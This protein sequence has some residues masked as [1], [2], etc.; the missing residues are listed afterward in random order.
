[1]QVP[2]RFP[3]LVSMIAAGL[4]AADLPYA[5]K[6]KLN[7]AKS[8]FGQLTV[9]YEQ[10]PGGE[11][12]VNVDGLSYSFKTDGQSYTT[13]WGTTSAW[14][15]IDANTWETTN[16]ANGKLIGTDTLKLSPDGKTL[17]I[18]SK[19]V[20]PTGEISNDTVVFQRVSGGPGLAGTWKTKNVK[21]SIP[22]TLD[23]APTGSDGLTITQVAE[24][25]VCAAKFDGKDYPATGP[26]WPSGWTCAIA[27]NGASAV[28]VTWKKDA[29]PMYKS[30]FTAS[31]DGKTLTE[32]G[33]AVATTEKIKAVY[34]RQ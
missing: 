21:M 25:G 32:S 34:D 9:A 19:N 16:K 6:W 22:A 7:P 11:M 4:I 12:K 13:P 8:D 24:Q 30:T 17:T 10:G 20:K 2:V 28:D 15:A 27:K 31:A 18:E 29:K 23:I 26:T 1:M 5:G 3:V 33:G 14:K